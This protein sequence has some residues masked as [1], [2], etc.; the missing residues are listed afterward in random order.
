M[1]D[2]LTQRLIASAAMLAALIAGF[3]LGSIATTS[4]PAPQPVVVTV[5]HEPTAAER[6]A[7]ADAE[8]EAYNR[9]LEAGK[10]LAANPADIELKTP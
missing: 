4:E 6:K 9:G 10:F 5:K 8:I 1:I 7:Q 3:A 2:N